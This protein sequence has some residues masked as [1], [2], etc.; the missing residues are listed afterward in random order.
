LGNSK[1]RIAEQIATIL[2]IP[3]EKISVKAKT[4]E[5]LGSV[6]RGEAMMAECIV[7]LQELAET[8]NLKS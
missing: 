4:G 3:P 5:G 2:A 7:L 1:R 8:G 6:G